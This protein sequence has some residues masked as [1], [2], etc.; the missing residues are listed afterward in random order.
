MEAVR[1]ATSESR[2]F[3]ASASFDPW[4]DLLRCDW[5]AF[6]EHYAE[7]FSFFLAH[8]KKE[9]HHHMYSAIRQSRQTDLVAE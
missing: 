3:L 7:A 1:D 2:S 8:K 5:E 6:V 9:S 4:E